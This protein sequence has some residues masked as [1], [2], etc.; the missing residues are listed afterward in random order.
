[1][2]V[3]FLA[4]VDFLAVEPDTDGIVAAGANLDRAFRLAV[5]DGMGEDDRAL[6][7]ADGL[8]EIDDAQILGGGVLSPGDLRIALA[9]IGRLDIDRLLGRIDVVE[10]DPLDVVEGADEVPARD[11][12]E[13]PGEVDIDLVLF[14]EHIADL[15]DL[16][17]IASVFEQG[18][19][20]VPM[21]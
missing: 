7:L 12:P 20:V 4:E 11:E 10:A 18:Q 8:V 13:V 19:V 5:K 1:A 15:V 17:A 9:D 2:V 16:I 14:L 21:V 3:I 6:E